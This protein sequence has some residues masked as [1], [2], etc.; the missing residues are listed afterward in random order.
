MGFWRAEIEA[1]FIA[2]GRVFMTDHW[3]V[4]GFWK[5]KFSDITLWV[6]KLNCR[7]ANQR[8]NYGESTQKNEIVEENTIQAKLPCLIVFLKK[9]SPSN[10]IS[11][12]L[13]IERWRFKQL[14]T[15]TSQDFP[16]ISRKNCANLTSLPIKALTRT[17]DPVKVKISKK[18]PK[19]IDAPS[20]EASYVLIRWCPLFV[21]Y[22]SIQ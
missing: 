16:E 22:L 17:I 21:S 20:V 13:C 18:Q 6:V 14:K 15:E 5:R 1:P 19:P 10:W 9:G 8:K 2:V 12:K 4:D 7:A 3:R 11:Q